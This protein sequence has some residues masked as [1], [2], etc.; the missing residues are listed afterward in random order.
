MTCIQAVQI[1]LIAVPALSH[2]RIAFAA[3]AHVCV[4]VCVLSIVVINI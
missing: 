2:S 1:A 3:C 4:C